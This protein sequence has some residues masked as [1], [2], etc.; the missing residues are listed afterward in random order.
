M[1]ARI[2]AVA[3]AL[4][5]QFL[6]SA[7]AAGPALL[8]DAGDGR[9]LYAEDLD[10]LWH[11]ASLTKIMTAYVT[12]GAIKEGMLKLHTSIRCSEVA[13]GQGPIK[14]G[15]RVGTTLTVE[16]ALQAVIVKSANDVSV[17]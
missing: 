7:A 4:G 13:N 3:V 17:M 2:A 10:T 1:R 11:P 14:A 5:V 12:F 6:P 9:V 15:I 16:N 8:F